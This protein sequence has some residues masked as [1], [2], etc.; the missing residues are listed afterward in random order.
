MRQSPATSQ[1]FVGGNS[2]K[3]LLNT[4]QEQKYLSKQNQYRNIAILNY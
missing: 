4:N 1:D 2:E 3:Q